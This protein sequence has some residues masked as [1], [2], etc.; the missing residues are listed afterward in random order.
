MCAKVSYWEAVTLLR[1]PDIVI[2]GGGLVGINAAISLK[3]SQPD[4]DVLILERESF[5]LGASTRNAGF[6]CFG[7]VTEL[8]DDLEQ[9]SEE[10][11]LSLLKSRVKGLGFLRNR[12][13]DEHLHYSPTG[14]YEV[15][16]RDD[17][18][19][20]DIIEKVPS[21]NDHILEATGLE[22]TF[23]VSKLGGQFNSFN[24]LGIFN[25]HEGAL[26][27]GKMMETLLNTAQ[28]LGVR[29]LYG[30]EVHATEE[31]DDR[32]YVKTR[33]HE[34]V[35]DQMLVCTN[36][37]SKKLFPE[38]EL[39][40]S[41]NQVLVT[42]PIPNLKINSCYHYDKGYVYFRNIDGRLLIGGGRNMAFEEET[43]ADFGSTAKIKNYLLNILHEKIGVSRDIQVAYEWSGIMGTG[44]IKTPI[45][46][47]HSERIIFAL[48]L[49]GMG[50]ALGA[51]L[52]NKAAN[53]L[54]N[55]T[56]K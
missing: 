35:C 24:T 18:L 50:V 21:L 29:I 34:F 4:L 48:R 10:N 19:L 27:P 3:E 39:Q 28:R 13:G 41:R 33:N 54:L 40:P 2:I 23:S 9:D 46:R 55:N 12:V 52:G 44:T 49:G 16:D 26:H 43:T 6:A 53:I 31:R 1:D 38:L 47:K 11:V 8:L 51:L 42:D 17:P 22:N 5:P 37:F 45:L 36:G 14:G 56:T 32:V 20:S 25:Q 15:F 30:M 7:S